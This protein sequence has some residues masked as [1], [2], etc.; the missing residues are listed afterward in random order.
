[1]KPHA[2]HREES[3]VQAARSG[4]WSDELAAHVATCPSCRESS[5]VARWMT[6]LA[7][8][9]KAGMAPLPDPYLIWL[10]ARIRR[11]A[12]GS[13]RALLPIRIAGV[14][15]AIGLAA[16]PAL[17][18]R[19]SWSWVQGWLT[20]GTA[21]VPELPNLLSPSLLG[22]LWLPAGFLVILLLLL[23]PGEA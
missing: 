12:R 23:A 9:V 11:R 15:S 13:R 5:R 8:T 4:R 21:L 6:E 22:A 16:I 7:E 18:P 2:C 1:M 19:E 3:V 10:K 14:L 17:L 20:S